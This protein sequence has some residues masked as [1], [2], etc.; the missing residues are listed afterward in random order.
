MRYIDLFSGAGGLSL[1]IKKA[2]GT[3]LYSNEMDF[4]ASNTQKHNLKFLKEDERKVI[5]SSIEDLHKEVIGKS[6]NV[7]YRS[8]TVHSHQSM[9]DSYK[10]TSQATPFQI[11]LI[12]SVS[13]VDLLVGGPP[14]QGF[15]NVARGKKKSFKESEHSFVDDPRNQLFKYFLDFVEFHSPKFV[16]IENVKGITSAKDY[17]GLIMSSLRK[18]NPG[19]IVRYD[20]NN[21]S[22]FSVP[23]NRERIFVLGIR[24]DLKDAENLDFYFPQIL[25]SF[26]N[27]PQFVLEDAI[28]DLPKIR[29]N[30]KK[31][32]AETIHE[33]EIGKKQ[34]W[35]E[36]V[37]T[38]KYAELIQQ[39]QPYTKL[40]NQ[41]RGK[42][43][44]PTNLYN[45]K[46]RY[47]ND[48]DLKAY[49]LMKPG[50]YLN[51]KENFD[52]V[53]IIPYGTERENG[54][55]KYTSS[56]VDKYFKLDPQKPSKT[57]TA[58]LL[59]DNNG[60]IHY[61]KIPR[62]ISIRE[63][64]RIQSFPDWFRFTGPFGNQFKQI[65]NAVPP[66]LAEAYG[67]IFYTFLNYGFNETLKLNSLK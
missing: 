10:Q 33:I 20:L 22:N 8:E 51:H 28:S 1:G 3:L 54:V 41:Y 49:K 43:L 60:F 13:D 61:G 15:S 58:H 50:K 64:A 44:K 14:C 7:E 38:K 9:R 32:N 23:Q 63:A 18:T 53:Q 29:S 57:I 47:N 48:L 45:H 55:M 67:K 37:S 66:L 17:L 35:G 24:K 34:S 62:G 56:F 21:A 40:I 42:Q 59:R 46:C 11:K 30:P 12:K 27:L 52:A 39:K 6:V 36:D 2:G 31:N 65:G 26:K 16:L 19:Y 5:T 25:E 4:H